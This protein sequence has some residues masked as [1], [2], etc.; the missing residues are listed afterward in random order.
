M[1]EAYINSFGAEEL[2]LFNREDAFGE[3]VPVPRRGS[4]RLG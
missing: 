1:N 4:R 2:V 3:A